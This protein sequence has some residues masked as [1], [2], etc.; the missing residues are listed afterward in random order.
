[1]SRKKKEIEV[2]DAADVSEPA[3]EQVSEALVVE[4]IA[5]VDKTKDT[6]ME[7]LGLV[8]SVSELLRLYRVSHTVNSDEDYR[9][10]GL[11]DVAKAL[12]AYKAKVAK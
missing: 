6:T 5:A 11:K 2:T 8:A 9:Y 7:T 4:S 1:M 12:S 10:P 3:P